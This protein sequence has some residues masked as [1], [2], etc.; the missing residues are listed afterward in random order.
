MAETAVLPDP[1]STEP[2]FSPE[3]TPIPGTSP[4]DMGMFASLAP[5]KA[6]PTASES[7]YPDMG[8]FAG[9][10][11]YSPT[12]STTPDM[13]MFANLPAATPMPGD[14]SQK[15]LTETK[16]E[17]PNIIGLREGKIQYADEMQTPPISLLYDLGVP[18]PFP[19]EQADIV[20]QTSA[21]LLN[22]PVDALNLALSPAGLST[23]VVLPGVKPIVQRAIAAGFTIDQIRNMFLAPT[24]QGKIQAG[25]GGLLTAIGVVKPAGEFLKPKQGEQN[26]SQIASPESVPV[27]EIRQGMGGEASLR[28][29]GPPAGARPAQR[30]AQVPPAT[31]ETVPIA[32]DH[33]APIATEMGLKYDGSMQSQRG[34]EIHH[35]TDETPGNQASIS[36]PNEI[37]PEEFRARVEAMRFARAVNPVQNPVV[38]EWTGATA[39]SIKA[40]EPAQPASL[41]TRLP[42]NEQELMS[43]LPMPKFEMRK[44]TSLDTA[45]GQRSSVLQNSTQKT[46]KARNDLR[47]MVPSKARREAISIYREAG[48]DSTVLAKQMAQAKSSWFRKAAQDAQK[49]TPKEVAA[50]G[51]VASAFDTMEQRGLANGVLKNHRDN[52]IPHVWKLENP[53]TGFGVRSLKK[54][55]KFA[56][57]RTFNTFFEGDQAGFKPRTLDV[58]DL[59]PGY[60]AEMDRVISDRQFVDSLV[61]LKGK[62]GNPLVIPRG[63]ISTIVDPEGNP[64]FMA[65]PDAQN[66]AFD[67]KDEPIDQSKYRVM[68]DQPALRSWRWKGKDAEGNPMFM[69][70]DLA[71]SPEAYRRV[72]AMM[73]QSGIRNWYRDVEGSMQIPKAI[74][75][76]LDI[77]QS[78]LKREMFGLLPPFHQVQEGWH[79]IGH[80]I[81]PFFGLEDFAAASPKVQDAITHGLMLLPD[82]TS[83]YQYFEGV[84]AHDTLITRGMRKIG[85]PGRALADVVDGYQQ[86]VFGSYIPRLKYST[87]ESILSRNLGRFKDELAKGEV[88]EADVKLLSGQQTNAAYGHLNYALLDRDPTFQH[89]LQLGLLAP[90]FLE[91]RGRFVAQAAKAISSKQGSEQLKAIAILAAVQATSAYTMAQLTGGE[92]DGSHPFEFVLNNRRYTLRSVPEDLM[93]LATDTRAFISAR[94]NPTLQTV[95]QMR[96]GINYRGEKVSFL[97]TVEEFLAKYIPLT[98]RSL[99]GLRDLTETSRNSPLTPLEQYAGSAGLKIS[100]YSPISET[101]KLADQWMK[102]QGKPSDTGTYPVSKYQQLRYALEDGDEDRAGV[103]YDKLLAGTTPEKLRQGFNESILH[104]FTGTK[105]SDADF[106]DSLSPQ[107]RAIYDLAVEKRKDMQQ[108]FTYLA[109]NR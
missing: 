59:V 87:Y 32:P 103:E 78:A 35:F 12:P 68:Q 14:E 19:G 86:Y 102:D 41:E 77:A 66:L 106:A 23:G 8:V 69:E 2:S 101:Y 7:A 65:R 74:V 27:P 79:G 76:G 31:Q 93:R 43:G 55:F 82:K 57:A 64:T 88:S 96:T 3:P 54:R 25:L 99:P 72:K 60:I 95:D 40:P 11:A 53:G 26:A 62:D 75:R 90:D 80:R 67:A 97:D 44:I 71:L 85:K 98:A 104:P 56:K 100:R 1:A 21:A 52:Y 42:V 29:P 5:Y 94:V 18:E 89:F 84:G 109:R 49:L 105:K 51:D 36:V 48:G 107:D 10:P 9:L 81:N 39:E 33:L 63:R 37:T 13:G 92:W 22:L 38:A 50:A 34:N 16:F 24:T 70:G 30:E 20:Q 4:V 17:M 61:G 108:K 46:L 91:A 73:G 15:A 47:K 58:A 83:G 28:Q 45:T 6:D